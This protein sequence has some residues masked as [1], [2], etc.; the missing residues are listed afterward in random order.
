MKYFTASWKR[1]KNYQ[2]PDE[3]PDLPFDFKIMM[4]KYAIPKVQDSFR[5]FENITSFWILLLCEFCLKKP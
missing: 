2:N 4:E 5:K 1:F 3:N